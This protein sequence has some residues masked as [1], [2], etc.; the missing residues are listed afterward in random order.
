MESAT[1]N[2][3][4]PQGDYLPRPT[5]RAINI[6]DVIEFTHAEIFDFAADHAQRCGETL[7]LLQ[8]ARVRENVSDGL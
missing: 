3:K 7:H 2:P 6:C 5:F 4:N 1:M 8:R